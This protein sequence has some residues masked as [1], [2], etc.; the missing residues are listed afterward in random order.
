[1]IELLR[2]LPLLAFPLALAGCITTAKAPPPAPAAHGPAV[3]VQPVQSAPL[4]PGPLPPQATADFAPDPEDAVMYAAIPA[5]EYTLPAINLKKS[6]PAFRRRLVNY[7]STE[8]PGTI[9]VDP[10]QRYLYFILGNGRAIRYGVGVGREGFGWTGEAYVHN[11]QEWPKWFPPADMRARQP[12]L[13]KYAPP[14]GMAGGLG[15]PLG[16]RAMYLWQGN[17]DTYYRLHGTNEPESIGH[18]MSSG[19]IRMMNQ[20]ALDLYNRTAVGAKVIVLP[21]KGA[22]TLQ[23]EMDK[24]KLVNAAEDAKQARLKRKKPAGG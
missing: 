19:C 14:N 4:N 5:G 15:N 8:A 22:S 16:A 3:P 24:N 2:R 12:E 21:S 6:N 17:H 11:K 10:G 13:R 23:A 1:M 18:N 20:D 9:I 7:P